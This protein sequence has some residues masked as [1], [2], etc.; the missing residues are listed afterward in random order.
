MSACD[1]AGVK[2]TAKEATARVEAWRR[3]QTGGSVEE[4]ERPRNFSREAFV[5]AI[6]EWIVADDQVCLF[7]IK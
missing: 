3:R 1:K 6:V 2:I 7:I 4:S 5:D